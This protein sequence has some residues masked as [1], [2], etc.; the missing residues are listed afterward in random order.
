MEIDRGDMIQAVK[1]QEQRLRLR[2]A[3][4]YWFLFGH[5]AYRRFVIIGHERTGSSM[6]VSYLNAHP[7]IDCYGE[8]FK[9]LNGR[10][11]RSIARL[12]FSSKSRKVL[13]VGFKMFYAHPL[14]GDHDALLNLVKSWPS[15]LII[16]LTRDDVV[17]TMTSLRIAE[18]TAVW[19][20]HVTK[21][22]IPLEK[23]KVHLPPDEVRTFISHVKNEEER[24]SAQFDPSQYVHITYEA[25]IEKPQ[26]IL[27]A[28]FQRL[29][30]EGLRVS[31][32]YK[33]I[34][35]EPLEHL[36]INFAELRQ[37]GLV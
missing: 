15:P 6:L 31:T 20:L 8:L 17:R 34:N 18:D 21:P 23:R 25:L 24:I 16:H 7:N 33:K 19:G 1:K 28:L 3:N 12:Y 9:R 29:G 30:V 5:H 32:P 4:L 35:P 11:V 37:Q 10:S 2:L 14:D 36:I 27:Q 26:E 13:A 22:E